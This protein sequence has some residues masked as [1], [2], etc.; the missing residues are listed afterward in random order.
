MSELSGVTRTDVEREI[1]DALG[2][3]GTGTM[4]AWMYDRLGTSYE[5]GRLVLRWTDNEWEQ[6]INDY[7]ASL[8]SGEVRE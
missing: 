4:A 8:R 7:L 5:D 1:Q 6:A 3:Q 2:D